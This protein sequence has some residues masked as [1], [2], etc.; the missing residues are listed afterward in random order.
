MFGNLCQIEPSP[1]RALN[2]IA[3]IGVA[4]NAGR[5]AVTESFIIVQVEQGCLRQR[6]CHIRYRRPGET[7]PLLLCNPMFVL[8]FN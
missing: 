8:G 4:G 3:R 6:G 5:G 1:F 2:C 7:L